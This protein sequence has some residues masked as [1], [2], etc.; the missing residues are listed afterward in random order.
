M[1]MGSGTTL[2][3]THNFGRRVVRR[4]TPGGERIAKPRTVA[5]ERLFLD[6][7]SPLRMRLDAA[8]RR[9]GIDGAFSFLP[10]LKFFPSD[11]GSFGGDVEALELKALGQLSADEA[12]GL[13]RIVGRSLALWSWFGVTDL[14]WE[15]LALGR[16]DD[17][18]IV[19]T[20]LDI[21]AIF[22]DL[23]LPTETKLLPDADQEVAEICRH[24]CG[25]RRVLPFLGKPVRPEHLVPMAAEYSRMLDLLDDHCDEIAAVVSGLP[26]LDE[27][28]IRVCLRGT[29]VYVYAM[30]GVD[31]PVWPPFLEAEEA[32]MARGDV[33]YFFRLI[34]QTGI[35]YYGDADLEIVCQIPTEGDVPRLEPLLDLTGGLCSPNRESLRTEGLFT[36]LG[37]FD[38][39]SFKGR[40]RESE[41]EI[42]FG[43]GVLVVETANEALETDR[44]L[45]EFVGSAYMPCRCGEVESVFVPPVTQCEV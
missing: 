25:V 26:S 27:T 41:M 16:T 28:P 38:D 37:A 22:E 13:A 39:P 44:D 2:G 15:N 33:P 32:R 21:E 31:R 36:I 42:E 14:H 4:S 1:V 35:W 34:G 10:D 7:D 19:F 8:A 43:D 23:R 6:A 3:D 17:S 12:Q 11:S 9:A 5:W 29:D 40:H 30:L 20:P 24:A 45:S 18:R